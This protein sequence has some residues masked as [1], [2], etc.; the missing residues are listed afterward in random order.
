MRRIF[1]VCMLL[2][3]GGLPL[4]ATIEVRSSHLTA[5]DGV[6]NSSVRCILQDSKGFIWMGSLNGLTRYD[7]THFVNF[8]QGDGSQPA[9][10]GH[11][12]QRMYE[13]KHGLLWITASTERISCFD[14]QQGNFIDYTGCGEFWDNYQN[15][16]HVSNGDTW[17]YHDKFGCRKIVFKEGK[18]ISQVFSEEK[19]NI[20][21]SG[22]TNVVEDAKGRI[23]IMGSNEIALLKDK[24]IVTLF[25]ASSPRMFTSDGLVCFVSQDGRIYVEH[26]EIIKEV[27]LGAKHPPFVVKDAIM[28]HN[29]LYLFTTNGG[30]VYNFSTDKL[31]RSKS[32]DVKDAKVDRD[33][34]GNYWIYNHTGWVWYVNAERHEV[35][36]FRL[37]PQERMHYVDGERYSF[38]HDSRDIVWISTYG[39]GLFAYDIKNDM[40]QHFAANMSGIG[41]V[42]SDYLL[43]VTED[44]S[45]SIW[46]CS[47]FTGVSQLSVV[48]E[49]A[50]YI[51][52]EG[53]SDMDDRSNSIRMLKGIDNQIWVGTRRGG[54]YIYDE[55]FRL[56]DS[57]YYPTNIYAVLKDKD[58]VIWMGSRGQG[59]KIGD[60]WY[61]HQGG[62]E[63]SISNNHIFDLCSD[64]SGRIW[65]GTFNGGLNLAMK[66]DD[67]SYA[68]RHFLNKSNNQSQIRA[69]CMDK[70]GYMWAGTSA[71]VYLFLP[72]SLIQNPDATIE[73]NNK[74]HLLASD[75]IKCLFQD[76]RGYMWIATSSTGLYQCCLNGD[77]RNLSVKRYDMSDGLVNNVV[78]AIAED[79]D[80]RIWISTEYG[81]SCYNLETETF[82]N[83]FFSSYSLGNSYCDNSVYVTPKG[84][85]LF[86]SN[87]GFVLIEPVKRIDSNTSFAP[88]V[89]LTELNVNGATVYSG[90]KKSPLEAD[91]AYTKSL[92]LAHN[93]NSFELHFST[94]DFSNNGTVKYQYKLDNYD[95]SWNAL[96]VSNHATYKN[97][98]P[99]TYLFRVKACNA[100]GAWSES[101]TTLKIK[102]L[103]PYWKSTWAYIIYF[104][105]LVAMSY[106][107][108]RMLAK[109]NSLRNRI[110]VEKQ[111]TDYKLVFFTNISHEFRTPLTLIQG[112][113]EKLST[114]STPKE[115]GES[116]KVMNKSTN[117]MLRLINQLLEFR[118]MQN[119]KLALS[120]EET[121][122]MAFL[123]EIFLSFSDVA[124]S[125]KML[126][127][128]DA[129]PE[130]YRMYID[131]ENLDKVTYNL[132]SN[133]FKY[134]P[135]GGKI[136]FAVK[137]DEQ[138]KKLVITVSDS[139]VG[140]PKEKQSELFNRFMQSSFSGSSVGV[141]LHLTHELVN[142]HKGTITFTENEGGGSI[143][144]VTLPTDES[145]YEKK[146]FLIPNQLM[147][148]EAVHHQLVQTEA[149]ADSDLAEWEH[150]PL[151][152]HKVLI[153]ED[154]NDVREFLKQEL[155]RYFEVEVAS[156][157]QAGLEK[158]STTEV[159]LIVCDVLMPGLSGFEVTSQLK[160]NF[161]TS[162]IPI[163]LL[164][165]LTSEDKQLEGAKCGA[166]SYITKPFSP[167]LLLTRIVKLI[168]QREKLREKFSNDPM[169]LRPAI[170][171]TDQDKE[172]VDRLQLIM[173]KQYSN[174]Q[175]SVD[176][177]ANMMKLGR[178]V[179]YK[180]VRGVTGYSPN[181][182]IRIVRMKKAAE[183]LQEGSLTVSE[184]AY[185]IGMNDPFYF[186]KCFKQQFGISPSAYQ[187]GERA[188][189]VE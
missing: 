4:K 13:D 3:L 167:K 10:G 140:I 120:L 132:L 54:V 110:E 29:E 69:L 28:L 63:T 27:A 42:T 162:H 73:I 89:V 9:L 102:V 104:L 188:S 75:E 19:G 183:L 141:G 127:R 143:F 5:M 24:R 2:L 18:F 171:T 52:P 177:F 60:T 108:F 155:E 170:C 62:D 31:Q 55:N 81:V 43:Y 41:H 33:N 115:L 26:D 58:D 185:K 133:A 147:H 178:T 118:K 50:T 91:I 95:K 180:K 126:F 38:V 85:I 48:N 66:Q 106:F 125:K 131:K 154:D 129:S 11:R 17:L 67:G 107:L 80:G 158:A 35:K 79:K 161:D 22:V 174:A 74:N 1:L 181:E 47:E 7:G 83:H 137:V 8:F 53:L 86:G 105:L 37:I 184:I 138:Q 136:I 146:D 46:V 78:Q 70:N 92:H 135:S 90:E 119:N 84:E 116:L 145:V 101:E 173:E 39:N 122:V 76:S 32:L 30:Y 57:N 142:V 25:T 20:S 15:S 165:A 114:S 189:N 150:A 151:N 34:K 103:P 56:I 157:G 87:Y 166:D 44:R 14:L 123:Y 16:L 65:I 40:L 130:N 45:G 152:K 168:E 49:G 96:S 124:D 156:D 99:G 100:Q 172:F 97:M 23:W 128:F 186:S 88:Q 6:A 182:Y 159:D 111:L 94:L 117:R 149:S 64:N 51:Y 164:T 71:G 77:Y 82:E 98:T 175:F 144:T 21:F 176:E 160:N 113:L 93:Q 169:M 61:K 139:G 12:I 153:I 68:F 72:D 109:L 112:A 187:K 121:D 148:D 59:L 134:T 163:I 36:K 179:F